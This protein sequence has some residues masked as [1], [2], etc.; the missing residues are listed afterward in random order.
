M[1]LRSLFKGAVLVTASATLIAV[2][3]VAGILAFVFYHS[4]GGRNWDV[5]VSRISSALIWDCTGYE[6]S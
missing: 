1:N 4:D 3:T 2:I 5:P 6:F